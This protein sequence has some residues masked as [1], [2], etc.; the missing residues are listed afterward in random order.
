M[1]AVIS[2]NHLEDRNVSPGFG[3]GTSPG[4]IAKGGHPRG[5][6]FLLECKHLSEAFNVRSINLFSYLLVSHGGLEITSMFES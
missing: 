4:A 6:L 1:S 5:K 3:T 2:N